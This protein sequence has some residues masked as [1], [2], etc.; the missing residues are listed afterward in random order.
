[1]FLLIVLWPAGQQGHSI[2]YWYDFHSHWWNK[3]EKAKD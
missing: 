2:D 1:M 3:F